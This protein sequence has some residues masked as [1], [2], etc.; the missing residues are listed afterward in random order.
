MLNSTY[1]GWRGGI[2]LIGGIESDPRDLK[3]IQSSAFVQFGQGCCASIWLQIYYNET[4]L[5][6]NSVLSV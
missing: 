1:A 2:I 5:L 3:S 4:G 6:T